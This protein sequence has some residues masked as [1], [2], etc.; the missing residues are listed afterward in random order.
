MA[1]GLGRRPGG[2]RVGGAGRGVL[3]GAVDEQLQQRPELGPRVEQRGPGDV[4][5]RRGVGAQAGRV[6]AGVVERGAAA[7][8]GER[9]RRDRNPGLRARRTGREDEGEPRRERGDGVPGAGPGGGPDHRRGARRHRKGTGAVHQASRRGGDGFAG[10]QRDGH[11]L[12]G[13]RAARPLPHFRLVPAG[14]RLRAGGGGRRN[15]CSTASP[16]TRP[17]WSI[18]CWS[19]TGK[20]CRWISSGPSNKATRWKTC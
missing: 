20:S 3:S 6:P 12:R 8:P 17:T 10:G 11:R 13:V 16:S 1:A 2:G 7:V 4:G 19:A 14:G 9:G 5:P 15:G 18:R